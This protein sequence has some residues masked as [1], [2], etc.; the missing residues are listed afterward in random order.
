[1]IA[2]QR[3]GPRIDFAAEWEAMCSDLRV[4]PDAFEKSGCGSFKNSSEAFRWK[5]GIFLRVQ[6]LSP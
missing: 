2:A 5:C 1:M 4:C 6:V 3:S